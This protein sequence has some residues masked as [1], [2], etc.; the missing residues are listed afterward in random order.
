MV[1]MTHP[2]STTHLASYANAI[3]PPPPI[4]HHRLPITQFQ[5]LLLSD[6]CDSDPWLLKSEVR[7][8]FFSS[9]FF[10]FFFRATS[11]LHQHTLSASVF[12][13]HSPSV[14]RSVTFV[15]SAETISQ[16]LCNKPRR[17]ANVHTRR[18]RNQPFLF[19]FFSSFLQSFFLSMVLYVF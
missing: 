14:L 15:L 17:E 5:G 10:L 1:K 18:Q 16:Q 11:R 6:C 3:A 4:P 19:L 12:S 8:F 2:C 9:V 7:T 13:F